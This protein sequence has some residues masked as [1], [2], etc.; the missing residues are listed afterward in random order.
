MSDVHRR[1]GEQLVAR[2]RRGKAHARRLLP[3]ILKIDSHLDL[4]ISPALA[5]WAKVAGAVPSF[6]QAID[7]FEGLPELSESYT[8]ARSP[9]TRIPLIGAKED[10]KEV[11]DPESASRRPAPPPTGRRPGD[12][13]LGRAVREGFSRRHILHPDPDLAPIRGRDDFQ[14]IIK[15]V[16]K[17]AEADGKKSG[18]RAADVAPIRGLQRTQ[19]TL[20]FAPLGLTPQARPCRR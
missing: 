18:A 16:E 13:G 8:L 14:Q 11:L 15:D 19:V 2:Q 20:V 6:R 4:A 12:R 9:H 5:N 3:N 7:P 10:R 17:E 1:R